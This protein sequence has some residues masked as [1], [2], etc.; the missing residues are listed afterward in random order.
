MNII[1]LINSEDKKCREFVANI[2]KND[3]NSY[4]FIDWYK[5]PEEIK[6]RTCAC[7][8]GQA[9]S[10]PSPSAFPELVFFDDLTPSITRKDM[11][12][13]KVTTREL[14]GL[15]RIRDAVSVADIKNRQ[16]FE[17]RKIDKPG[18]AN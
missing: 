18:G 17:A 5:Q 2:P 15:V 13:S 7:H 1:V 11:T 3:G 6:S 12:G 10:G 16:K 4:C 8:L 14:P 9:Y